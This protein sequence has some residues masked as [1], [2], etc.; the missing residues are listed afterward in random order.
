[1]QSYSLWYVDEQRKTELLRIYRLKMAYNML[2]ASYQ[3]SADF[4]APQF[5]HL[6]PKRPVLRIGA[7]TCIAQLL[8]F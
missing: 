5:L 3:Q 2:E 7:A 1:M 8:H 4:F 6:K